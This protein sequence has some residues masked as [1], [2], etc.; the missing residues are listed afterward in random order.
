MSSIDLAPA[1]TTATGVFP[2]SVRSEETSMATREILKS[3]K[4]NRFVTGN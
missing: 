4:I 2:S 1:E 3:N